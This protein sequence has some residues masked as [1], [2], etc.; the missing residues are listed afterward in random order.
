MSR[1]LINQSQTAR[2]ADAVAIVGVA[3]LRATIAMLAALRPAIR[4][5]AIDPLIALRQE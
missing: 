4:A 1:F 2:P 3:A 5:T